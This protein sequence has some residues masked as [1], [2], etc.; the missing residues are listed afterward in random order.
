MITLQCRGCQTLGEVTRRTASL[1]C[2][3]G[4]AEFV[5]PGA[6]DFLSFM[7]A[8]VGTAKQAANQDPEGW[9]EY[10]GPPPGPNPMSNHEPAELRCKDCGG[11]G[12]NPRDNRNNGICRACKGEGVRARMTDPKGEPLVARHPGRST[13]TTVPF[14]GAKAATAARCI[15]AVTLDAPCSL[16][17]RATTELRPDR[18]EHAWLT[19][20]ACGPLVDL[21]ATP[22]FNPYAHPVTAPQRG[23]RTA[24]LRRVKATG[25]VLPMVHTVTAANPGLSTREVLGLVRRTV[26][27]HSE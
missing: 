9:D 2:T 14:F 4:S 23:Y 6:G 17:K 16:C 10:Q 18:A 1:R 13:Q 8:A 20:A 15:E 21:D 12:E 11:T 19:C 27:T 22:G 5:E 7:G 24:G 3:C 25:R 26:S